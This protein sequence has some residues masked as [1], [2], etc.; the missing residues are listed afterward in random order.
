VT[1]ALSVVL[2]PFLFSMATHTH[3]QKYTDILFKK[4]LHTS[5]KQRHIINIL[6]PKGCIHNKDKMITNEIK[7][8]K[9]N[10][11]LCSSM[12]NTWTKPQDSRPSFLLLWAYVSSLLSWLYSVSEASSEK[13]L[14]SWQL[15]YSGNTHCIMRFIF[16]ARSQPTQEHQIRY[17]T[18][19]RAATEALGNL[20]WAHVSP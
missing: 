15:Q 9:E 1:P 10:S 16:I 5:N 3:V 14:N 13:V 6:I 8:Q 19:C 11:K 18:L 12:S 20:S 2:C 17:L 7:S 4:M